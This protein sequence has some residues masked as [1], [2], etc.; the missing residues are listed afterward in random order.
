MSRI[1]AG[2]TWGGAL[3]LAAALFALAGCSERPQETERASSAKKVD[4][5][6]WEGASPVYTSPGGTTGDRSSWEA[7]LK[8]RNQA[9]NEYVRTR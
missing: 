5:K 3:W 4:A 9:Q 2:K 8:A 6:A 7:E 1:D